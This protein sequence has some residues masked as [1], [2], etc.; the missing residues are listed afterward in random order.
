MQRQQR[1]AAVVDLDVQLVDRAVAGQHAVDDR[2]VA[3]DQAL[4]RRAHVFLGEP[5]HLEQPRLE[6]LELFLKVR[7]SVRP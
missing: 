6:L 5:A 1:E 7:T 4:D 3:L 2:R